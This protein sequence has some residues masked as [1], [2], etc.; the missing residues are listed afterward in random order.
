[1][2]HGNVPGRISLANFADQL[3]EGKLK[4]V[5]DSQTSAARLCDFREADRLTRFSDGLPRGQ[6]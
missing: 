4:Y 1:M 3:L 5:F 2:L 6:R